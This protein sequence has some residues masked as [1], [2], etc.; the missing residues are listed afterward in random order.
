MGLI[1]VSSIGGSSHPHPDAVASRY[2]YMY[3]D[4]R[5]MLKTRSDDDSRV[6]YDDEVSTPVSI[7]Y[8]CYAQYWEQRSSR[9]RQPKNGEE[10]AVHEEE[11]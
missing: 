3:V 8:A 4:I 2:G 6:T 1:K 7:P 10:R 5:P 11:C 9:D